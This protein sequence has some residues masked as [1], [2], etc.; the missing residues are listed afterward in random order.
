VSIFDRL[1]AAGV[2]LTPKPPQTQYTAMDKLGR[3]S[4]AVPSHLLLNPE[5]D[6][7]RLGKQAV[8]HSHDLARVLELPRRA[9]DPADTRFAQ[10][11]TRL[12]RNDTS[13]VGCSCEAQW[14]FCIHDLLPIQGSG[15][16]EANLARGL[17]GL[18]GVGSGKCLAAGS[19]IY[20]VALG[21]RRD[22][23]EPGDLCVPTL[24]RGMQ[25]GQ[26]R[27]FPSGRKEC[28]KVRLRDGAELVAS[29]DHPFLEA[30]KFV[31]AD[32]WTQAADLLLGQLVAVPTR[33]PE[34][35][36][37]L[38]ISDDEVSLLGLMFADG[39]LTH[40]TLRF[41]DENADTV[42]EFKRCARALGMDFS[43]DKSH[44]KSRE[45][46]LL[47]AQQFRAR[48]NLYALSKHKQLPPELWG[49]ST[50]H[51]ALFLSRFWACDGHYAENIL[52][53][54]LAS[55]KLVDDLR[56]LLLRIGV[57]TTKK[58]KKARCKGKLFD[59][60]RISIS[61]QDA[62]N[63][64]QAV[65]LFA[66]VE[67]RRA[68]LQERLSSRA[69]N[70]NVDVVP[71][72]RAEVREICIEMGWLE[73]KSA[74][75]E[76]LGA[77]AGQWVSRGKFAA[78]CVEWGYTGKYTKL[79]LDGFAWE[80]VVAVEPVGVQEVFDLNVPETHN[81]VANNIVVHNTGLDI[82]LPLVVPEC[83]V[84]LLLIPPNLKAQFLQRDLPQWSQHFRVPNLAGGRTFEAG[85]P[86][87]HVVAYS[88]LSN[89]KAT[90]LI[91][92]V[93]PDL[94]IADECHQISRRDAARTKR[95]MRHFTDYPKTRFVALSGTLT[96]RSLQDY[97][98]LSAL[99]LHEGS[100]L[101]LHWPTVEEWAGAIDAEKVTTIAAPIGALRKLCNPGEHVREGFRR[102][103][104]ETSGVVAT[105]EGVLGTSLYLQERT[106][107]VPRCVNEALQGVRMTW[108]RPDGEEL[109][110]ALTKS[111]VC[112]QLACGFYYRWIWPRGEPPPVRE[113]WLKARR[114]WH[115]EL[116]EKLK[117]S[118]EHMDSPLL[119]TRAAHRWH[120]GFNEITEEGRRVEHPPHTRHR[121]T[122]ASDCYLEWQRVKDSAEPQTEAVWV[123]D[124]LVQDA[125]RWAKENVGLIWYTHS[126]FGER[127]ASQGQLPFFGPGNEANVALL[128]ERGDRSIVV[129]AKAHGTGKNLQAWSRNL[130]CNPGTSGK[131][132]EQLLGRTHRTGQ[133]AD[134][135][136]A[137]VYRQTEEMREAL[138]QAMRDA[139][140]VAQS[141]GQ[142]QKLLYANRDW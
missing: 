19:V 12:L 41:S 35:K 85:I 3:T 47:G 72:G 107:Q 125:A 71:I 54:T 105:Q 75:R 63:F 77:T 79:L 20:D 83:R 89:A 52:E 33:L 104:V 112:R 139:R 115:R 39:G 28:V 141:T 74:A 142:Q 4:V 120:E 7:T 98:H 15:C 6:K 2:D 65:P 84:A 136:F 123:D 1:K 110:D 14:G 46:N 133:R 44:S 70:T 10:K 97:A 43:E 109:T 68:R 56:F 117:H 55:E 111:A 121:M 106:L 48:W 66:D 64:L 132:W 118:R 135:V 80:R 36:H 137:E 134:E 67:G 42:Q 13:T 17:L 116:R 31:A 61:G 69:R 82:L 58:F 49:L 128:K 25:V 40:S 23:A 127:L 99:A 96:S 5:P 102:R 101:P 90:D 87:L 30:T 113:T 16:E 92:R 29:T 59:A 37:P 21:R 140:Y 119:L 103:L 88:E 11:W 131:D 51:V 124:Y 91:K 130:I 60:W 108:Q 76:W 94:I 34:P 18:L 8:A 22:V 38:D 138:D 53:C 26:A 81:F 24:G 129:S 86:V 50:K 95:F 93:R 27:A 122:W 32:A 62:V 78:F 45:M 57:R 9:L 114:E 73:R 100:P 126:A